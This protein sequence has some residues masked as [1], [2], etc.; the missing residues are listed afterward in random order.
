M[1]STLETPWE[2]LIEV[3]GFRGRSG[4]NWWMTEA[5]WRPI[6]DQYVATGCGPSLGT[7]PLRNLT[8]K[9]SD[10]LP[11]FNKYA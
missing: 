1:F 6:E 9:G 5:S 4:D 7:Q 10:G 8:S 11:V 2:R 3:N